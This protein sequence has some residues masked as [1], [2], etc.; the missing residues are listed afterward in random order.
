MRKSSGG[1]GKGSVRPVEMER[2]PSSVAT[3]WRASSSDPE[4]A[5]KS[6]WG[7]ARKSIV[8]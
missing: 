1:E 4:A 3:S 5:E 7:K 6:M 8:K 2:F